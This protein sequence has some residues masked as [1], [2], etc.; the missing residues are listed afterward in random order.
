M[1]TVTKDFIEKHRTRA[2]GW[3]RAQLTCI[4]VQWPPTH[5]W[6]DRAAGTVITD[7]QAADFIKFGAQGRKKRKNT[8]RQRL[9]EKL[10]TI[11]EIVIGEGYPE[12][13]DLRRAIEMA[14]ALA[15]SPD[16]GKA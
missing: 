4:G 2:G 8:T 1:P 10:E 5:G 12:W 7:E 13:H 15:R 11:E 14:S 16:F 9:I 6:Q 3:T